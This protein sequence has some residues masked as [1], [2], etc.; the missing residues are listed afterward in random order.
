VRQ[1]AE[2]NAK[3]K[4]VSCEDKTASLVVCFQFRDSGLCS[5]STCSYA[6]V[7][8]SPDPPLSPLWDVSVPFVE[9]D[10][11]C[12]PPVEETAAKIV[13]ILAAELL[14]RALFRLHL[15]R[16]RRECQLEFEAGESLQELLMEVELGSNFF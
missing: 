8:S 3:D 5:R 9:A 7:V 6:H 16:L 2:H 10:P 12:T 13:I 14:K 1:A 11:P 4:V 15:Q